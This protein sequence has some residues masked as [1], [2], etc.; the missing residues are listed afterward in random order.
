MLS[1]DRLS[2]LSP[3]REPCISSGL[4]RAEIYGAA[5]TEKTGERGEAVRKDSGTWLGFSGF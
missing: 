4:F 5:E 1:E 3:V 2:T